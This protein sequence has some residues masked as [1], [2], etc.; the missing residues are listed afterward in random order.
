MYKI[1]DN[2]NLSCLEASQG[3]DVGCLLIRAL[4]QWFDGRR[5]WHMVGG[6]FRIFFGHSLGSAIFT[7]M[8]EFLCDVEEYAKRPLSIMTPGHCHF[9]LDEIVIHQGIASI[10]HTQYLKADLLIEEMVRPEGHGAIADGMFMLA[11]YFVASQHYLPL[12][13]SNTE[14]MPDE[15]LM[16]AE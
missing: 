11:R 7:R 10:Q 12:I 3:K 1:C 8:D 4:R 2:D 5:N 6:E 16:A 15:E 9:G 14:Q 13:E